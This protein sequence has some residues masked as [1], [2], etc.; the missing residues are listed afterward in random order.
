MRLALLVL[1][2]AAPAA[3]DP[4]AMLE[5]AERAAPDPACEMADVLVHQ[6]L[7]PYQEMFHDPGPWDEKRHGGPLLVEIK[8][9]PALFPPGTTCPYYRDWTLDPDDPRLS[10]AG[11]WTQELGLGG[12]L[13]IADGATWSVVLQHATA[14][15]SPDGTFGST[16]CYCACIGELLVRDHGRWRIAKNPKY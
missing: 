11:V 7:P 1:V 9:P 8:A 12:P 3:A 13:A 2:V 4:H 15:G 10:K 6:S 14:H 16:E 5:A